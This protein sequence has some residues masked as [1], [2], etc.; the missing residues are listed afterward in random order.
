MVLSLMGFH[1][2]L[3]PQ[4]K[5]CFSLVRLTKS[6]HSEYNPNKRH[7]IRSTFRMFEHVL[8]EQNPHWDGT[9]Y[10]QGIERQSLQEVIQYLPLHHVISVTGVRRA[11]KSTIL[12]QTINH[13]IQERH[14]PPKNILFM[15]LEHPYFSQYS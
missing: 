15:N 6:H 4:K 12:K 9:L 10:A 8:A 2:T 13:L 11:G 5:K 14:V 1:F 3:P 7:F